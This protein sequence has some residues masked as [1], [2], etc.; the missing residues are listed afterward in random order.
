[1][2]LRKIKLNVILRTVG[3]LTSILGGGCV[4][5]NSKTELSFVR[6][7][8]DRFSGF[9]RRAQLLWEKRI[10]K[11]LNTMCTELSVPLARRRG[12]Q[13]QIEMKTKW[14]EIGQFNTR[15]TPPPP[16][17]VCCSTPVVKSS[18]KSF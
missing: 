10:L 16:P 9:V 12:K 7:I 15:L 5:S 11:S 3:E 8:C 14:N 18:L 13:E 6:L 1:M 2:I 17:L 4:V